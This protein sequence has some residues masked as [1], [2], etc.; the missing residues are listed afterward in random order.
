[1]LPTIAARLL[2]RAVYEG[3]SGTVASALAAEDRNQLECFLSDDAAEGL[4]SFGAK[5]VPVFHGR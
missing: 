3:E 5:R 4:T 2:K 1:M